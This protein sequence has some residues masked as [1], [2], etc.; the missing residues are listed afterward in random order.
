MD[1]NGYL[2]YVLEGGGILLVRTSPWSY[3]LLVSATGELEQDPLK[4]RAWERSP[5]CSSLKASCSSEG[6]HI[7]KEN[8]TLNVEASA[9]DCKAA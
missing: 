2:E 6:F 4:P 1:G 9:Q 8:H 7:R 5:F 3:A